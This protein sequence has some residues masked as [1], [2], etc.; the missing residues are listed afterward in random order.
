MNA[1]AYLQSHGWLGPGHALRATST[2][3][4]TTDAST[5]AS[6]STS[7]AKSTATDTPTPTNPTLVRPSTRDASN[8]LVHPLLLPRKRNTHGVGKKPFSAALSSEWWVQAFERGLRGSGTPD[9][10]EQTTDGAAGILGGVGRLG[11]AKMGRGR[12]G[13]GRG[14]LW[15]MFVRGEGESGTFPPVAER[16]TNIVKENEESTIMKKTD[17]DEEMLVDKRKKKKKKETEKGKGKLNDQVDDVAEE[18][19]RQL[20]G[21]VEARAKRKA[22]RRQKKSDK[23]ERRRR[24]KAKKVERRSRERAVVR[25]SEEETSMKKK[26]RRRDP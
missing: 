20:N 22:E 8:D 6:T 5:S 21:E 10:E 4:T 26:K 14:L 16:E 11:D 13:Q 25:V 19:E 9:S 17:E 18:D 12:H 15:G 3:T 1:A 7:I 2:H 23:E 24:R